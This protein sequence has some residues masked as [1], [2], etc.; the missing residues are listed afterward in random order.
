MRDKDKDKVNVEQEQAVPK[1]KA[2]SCLNPCEIDR[3]V[4]LVKIGPKIELLAGVTRAFCE[5]KQSLRL[6]DNVNN[7]CLKVSFI[8]SLGGGA[9]FIEECGSAL[10]H[11]MR[12]QSQRILLKGGASGGGSVMDLMSPASKAGGETRPSRSR[13]PLSVFLR[14]EEPKGTGSVLQFPLP[15][16]D[17][18]PLDY[19]WT[20][21]QRFLLTQ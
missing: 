19:K 12:S 8:L 18:S 2:W 5:A 3:G 15:Q 14:A 21:S 11:I 13:D 4:N 1:I 9:F 7:A 20:Q 10:P 17:R 6:G 16:G